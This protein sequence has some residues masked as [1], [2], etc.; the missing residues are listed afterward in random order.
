[1]AWDR[2]SY[3]RNKELL[4][5]RFT[6]RGGG[7][8]SR[9]TGILSAK[10]KS[11]WKPKILGICPEM[12]PVSPALVLAGIL[13]CFYAGEATKA[14]TTDNQCISMNG[15]PFESCSMAGYNQTFPLPEK[16]T[17]SQKK[18]MSRG[19]RV[20]LKAIKS[21]SQN[22]V[23][24]V[25]TCSVFAPKCVTGSPNPVL[26]CRRVC[27]E[28]LKQCETTLR[29]FHLDYMV[30]L[31]LIL[32]NKTASSGTCFEPQNFRTND[33]VRGK[34]CLLGINSLNWTGGWQ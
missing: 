20:M 11:K 21:C 7:V 22:N 28:F 17:N 26:P 34:T 23:A 3:K 24:D 18:G 27:G 33:S 10:H 12:R 1:M 30:G 31:C 32:P 16:I 5:V 19:L 4:S 9:L 8:T 13:F 25:M 14:I 6:S 29:R 15:G 2:K